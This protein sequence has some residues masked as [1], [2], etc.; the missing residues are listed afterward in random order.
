VGY[1][2]YL[3]VEI[4]WVETVI[5][6]FTKKEKKKRKEEVVNG[7]RQQNTGVP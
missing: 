4:K 1:S 3:N 5:E 7:K 6:S 2:I